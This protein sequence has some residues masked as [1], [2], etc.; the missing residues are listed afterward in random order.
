MADT[1]GAS[2]MDVTPEFVAA[3]RIVVGSAEPNI[4]AIA[5]ET[6]P[7]REDIERIYGDIINARRSITLALDPPQPDDPY[8][9]ETQRAIDDYRLNAGDADA[10]KRA[11]E[12]ARSSDAWRRDSAGRRE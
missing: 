11:R 9:A 8:M 12:M 1:T 4:V 2:R 5:F 10:F 3:C 7:L 6:A